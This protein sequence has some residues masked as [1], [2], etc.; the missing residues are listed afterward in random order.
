MLDRT[1]ILPNATNRARQHFSDESRRK[2]IL[3]STVDEGC[4]RKDGVSVL[5]KKELGHLAREA[6]TRISVRHRMVLAL[7]L[8]EDM[9]H[10][11]VAYVLGCTELS[12]RASFFRATPP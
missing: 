11:E 5:S 8:Y 1:L 3:L 7:R 10:A 2:A 9:P 6:M 4:L 12:A